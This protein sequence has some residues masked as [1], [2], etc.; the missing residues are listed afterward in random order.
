M[1]KKGQ[2]PVD[3]LSA[4]SPVVQN[5]AINKL[6]AQVVR[7]NGI[8]DCVKNSDRSELP[9]TF[10]T[11]L[12]S[13]KV[14]D[15][16][17]SGRC[18]IFAALNCVRSEMIS[19]WDLEELEFSQ[20]Y[21]YFY[22]KLEKANYFLEYIIA[23]ASHSLD[24]RMLSYKLSSPIPDGG[25]WS[26]FANLFNKYGIVPKSCMPETAVSITTSDF[27]DYLSDRLR[28]YASALRKM[29]QAGQSAVE[30][31]ERKHD[32]I[33]EIHRILCICLGTPPR[34]FDFDWTTRGNQRIS[35]SRITPL[36]F[37][38][39]YVAMN[40]SDHICLINVPSESKP[41][42]KSY[43]IENLG[44]L[45]E[46]E[47][48]QYLNVPIADMKRLAIRQLNE[49]SP[50]WFG[51]DIRQSVCRERG[52][53]DMTLYDYEAL[54]GIYQPLSKGETFDYGGFYVSHAM[55]L[56]GVHIEDKGHSTRWYVENSVGE[57]C[58]QNGYCIMTDQWFESYV[59]QAVIH[60]S[61]LD[62]EMIAAYSKPPEALPPWDPIALL[63]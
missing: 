9:F 30:M 49:G 39:K 57:Q 11:M 37:R 58:G 7:T 23:T 47:A 50:V 1:D 62:D 14:T 24:D 38:R 5:N 53:F 4:V 48:I 27:V 41:F 17:S 43:Y 44:N 33:A 15:Q 56:Q 25:H 63:A 26:L 61:C 2:L 3:L 42:Y 20:N 55:V 35:E 22:D 28:E 52:I 13:H 19:R 12:P 6:A 54:F 46:G 18:W 10:S 34:K 40:P 16:K 31:R 60:R 21:L 45:V 36:D 29:H 32:M 8:L 51:C 59:H